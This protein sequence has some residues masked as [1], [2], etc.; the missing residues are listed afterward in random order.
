MSLQK[1]IARRINKTNIDPI[2]NTDIVSVPLLPPMNN[3]RLHH[4]IKIYTYSI[5]EKI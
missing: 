2:K 5:Y 4:I 3:V 1:K